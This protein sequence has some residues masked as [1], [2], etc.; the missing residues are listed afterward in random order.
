V[1]DM[2]NDIPDWTLGEATRKLEH[3]RREAAGGFDVT[4]GR[5]LDYTVFDYAEAGMAVET[6]ATH[7][8]ESIPNGQLERTRQAYALLRQGTE[9]LGRWLR[10][11]GVVA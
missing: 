1:I 7:L 3:Q 8:R 2:A 11:R 9:D 6:A 10:S 5:P 4:V